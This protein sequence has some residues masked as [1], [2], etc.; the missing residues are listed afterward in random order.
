MIAFFLIILVTMLVLF[1]LY[2]KRSKS[3]FPESFNN[4]A[5]PP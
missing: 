3:D 5:F 4:A 2:S 1:A